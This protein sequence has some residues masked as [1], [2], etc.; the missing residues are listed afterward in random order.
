[1]VSPSSYETEFLLGQNWVLELMAQGAP[2][3]QILDFLLRLVQAQCPGMQCSILLM[4]RDGIHMRH[5]AAPDLPEAYTKL[6]DGTA[7]GPEVGSCGTAAYR[8]APVIVSDIQ[9]DPLWREFRAIASEFGLRACWSTPIFDGARRLLGTFAMYFTTPTK[10]SESLVLLTELATH[11]A[12]IAIAKHRADEDVKARESQLVEAQHMAKLGS[13]EWDVETNHFA[14][15]EELC[16]IFGLAREEFLPSYDGYLSRVH[17]DDRPG[18]RH[19]MDAS[20]RDGRPLDFTERIV[21]PDGM[22]RILRNQGKWSFD[23]ARR[24]VKLIG[25]CQDITE[26]KEIER[27]LRETNASL[28]RELE[29]RKRLEDDIRSQLK[30]AISALHDAATQQGSVPGGAGIERVQRQLAQLVERMQSS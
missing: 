20:L 24:P 6:I 23:E 12:S 28:E 30:L 29:E 1:M 3:R 9:T 8:R 27:Q 5:G 10:P 25:I 19:N 11:I 15:S 22:I 7:I 4:D 26:P 16:R 17:P 2:L 18:T 21:R 13:Y 14:P